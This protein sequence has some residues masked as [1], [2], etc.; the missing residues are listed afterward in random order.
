[1]IK[2]I[3]ILLIGLISGLGYSFEQNKQ[4][5]GLAYH[6]ESG[7]LIYLEQHLISY[8]DGLP[9]EETINY[10][11]PAGKLIGTKRLNYVEPSAPDYELLFDHIIRSEQVTRKD[12]SIVINARKNST[13]PIPSNDFA[14]DGGFHYFIL[15]NF[16][17]LL[18]KK[19]INFDFLSA[20]RG[21]FVPLRLEP[22]KNDGTTLTVEIRFNH[23]LLSRFI[24]P[25]V[26]TYS[27]PDR[28]MLSYE[29]LTNVPKTNSELFVARIEYQYDTDT[30]SFLQLDY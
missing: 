30:Q 25:I 22:T 26:L 12:N 11:T 27:I 8:I 3:T 13:V 23:F 15:A 7:E 17:S 18:E 20:S 2:R 28:Q 24:D 14:I 6:L 21:D 29:G 5:T 1:M 16:D 4:F 10:L 9:S 19:R